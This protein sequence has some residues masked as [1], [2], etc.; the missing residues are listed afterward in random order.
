ML[1]KPRNGAIMDSTQGGLV[2]GVG[3]TGVEPVTASL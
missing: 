2:I 3:A 1:A